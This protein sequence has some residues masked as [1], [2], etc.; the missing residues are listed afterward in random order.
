MKCPSIAPLPSR[1][2]PLLGL[3]NGQA[4][5]LLVALSAFRSGIGTSAKECADQ[6]RY[7]EKATCNRS[8]YRHSKCSCRHGVDLSLQQHQRCIDERED[9]ERQT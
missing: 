5:F 9:D 4:G 6:K 1:K 3:S 7:A 2:P 8:C